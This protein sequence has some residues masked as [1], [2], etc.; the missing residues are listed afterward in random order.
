MLNNLVALFCPMKFD[1]SGFSFMKLVGA[2]EF[3]LIKFTDHP[4]NCTLSSGTT[5]QQCF[6]ASRNHKVDICERI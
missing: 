6:I 3:S 2:I 4:Q 5:L 1:F